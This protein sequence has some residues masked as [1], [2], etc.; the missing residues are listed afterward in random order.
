[1]PRLDAE[2]DELY[3]LPLGE[4]TAGRNA[5][6]KRAGTEAAGIRALAKPT[7]AAWAVNQLYWKERSIH[8]RL[9]ERAADLRSTHD[10]ALHGK[11]TDLRGASRAH[12]EAVEEALKATLRLLAAEG[13]PV[14]DA[15]RQAIATTLRGLPGSEPPGRLTR[16]LDPLG[17]A[18]L[19][20]TGPQGKVRV[21]A[22]PPKPAAATTTRSGRSDAAAREIAEKERA[23][24]VAELREAVAEA[25]RAT[26]EAEGIVRREQFEAAR[27]R[28]EA[29]KA[30]RHA[31]EAE[32]ALRQAQS[33]LEE[34][35]EAAAAAVR[36]RDEAHARAERAAA[37]LEDARRAEQQVRKELERL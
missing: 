2:I 27:A 21:P 11:R 26:R 17:F 36:A 5:L 6:A 10:A 16:Q 4:F 31:E 3:K 12:E 1:M 34:A 32:E 14:T 20:A 35:K 9:V 19:A 25:A 13:H 18:T 30:Q 29:E 22:A 23:A 37:G 28:R 7:L 33:E 8:D 24:R 15:T